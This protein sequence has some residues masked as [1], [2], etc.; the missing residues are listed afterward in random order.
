MVLGAHVSAAA[1]LRKA[2]DR[3]LQ[4][5]IEAVQICTR[6]ATRWFTPPIEPEEVLGFRH[7]AA[8][9]DRANLLAL[10]TF[11]MMRFS[12]GVGNR[13]IKIKDLACKDDPPNS[14]AGKIHPNHNRFKNAISHEVGH[15]IVKWYI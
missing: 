9:F 1:G 11:S 4:L 3:A 5:E 8:R 15:D 14:C 2:V 6:S 12:D 10:A 7:K 13:S